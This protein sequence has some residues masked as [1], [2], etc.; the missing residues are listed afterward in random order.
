MGQGNENPLPVIGHHAAPS[1]PAEGRVILRVMRQRA[2]ERDVP[3]DRPVP[4]LKGQLTEEKVGPEPVR[5]TLKILLE[6]Q[7]SN[8]GPEG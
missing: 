6:D 4:M 3:R 5:A 8:S 2:V 1:P 7:P